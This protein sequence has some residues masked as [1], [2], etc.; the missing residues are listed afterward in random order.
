MKL[1]KMMTRRREKRERR[2]INGEEAG[3]L[4]W[5]YEQLRHGYA[6]IDS[7]FEWLVDS[8]IRHG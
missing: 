3:Y 7:R 2:E 5:R 8:R 4:S 6:W 1:M